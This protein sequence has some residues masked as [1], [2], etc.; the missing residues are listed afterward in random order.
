M[1]L[2]TFTLVKKYTKPILTIALFVFIA[3]SVN[4]WELDLSRRQK[5]VRK[6]ENEVIT[7]KT[8]AEADFIE[9]VFSAEPMQEVVILNTESGFIP[10]TVR[11]KKEGKYTV[12][13]VNVNEKEKNVSFI[14]DQFGEHH[15]TYYGKKVSFR[16]NPKKEG[17]YAYQCPETNAE[18]RLVVVGVGPEMRKPAAADDK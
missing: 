9:K 18:G 13:V 6:K 10:S 1:S 4:A 16:L 8:G 5:T 7:T 17:I 12:H 11:L 15:G 3:T 2:P 14:M